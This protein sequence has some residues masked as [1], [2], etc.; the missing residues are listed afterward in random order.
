MGAV[1]LLVALLVFGLTTK[2]SN[3]RIDQSLSEGDAAPAPSF[4]LPILE[5]AELPPVLATRLRPAFGDGRLDLDELRGVPLVLNLWASWCDPCRAEA[6]VLNRG[7]RR[8]GRQG[9]L[10]LGLNMQDLTADARG[11]LEEFEV[12]YASIREQGNE[13][14]LTY[15]ATG[16]PETYFID[17]R[18]RVVAHVVGVVSDQQLDQGASAART[19]RVA[20]ILTGGARREQR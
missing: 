16:I 7:W 5:G 9:V 19:G 17:G 20:G 15:G 13:L 1:L 8:H 12:S 10:Y 3:E 4:D 18:G 11:F 6:P 2:A 14:A